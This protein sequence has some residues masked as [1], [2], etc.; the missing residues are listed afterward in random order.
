[1]TTTFQVIALSSIDPE[2]ID[3]RDE[4]RLNYPDAVM[5]SKE[6]RAQGKAFR[7]FVDG[8]HTDEQMQ[9]FIKL[10]ALV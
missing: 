9:T 5:A 4:P 6:F 10:G 1:M 2:G 7:V 8:D 3:I